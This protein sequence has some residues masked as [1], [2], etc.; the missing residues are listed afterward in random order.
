ME[1]KLKLTPE[2]ESLIRKLHK[3]KVTVTMKPLSFTDLYLHEPT[4]TQ[5]LEQ[6]AESLRDDR[7]N[8]AF[9]IDVKEDSA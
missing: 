9:I 5:V 8:D 7:L 1:L 3:Y 6:I 4:K 2:V